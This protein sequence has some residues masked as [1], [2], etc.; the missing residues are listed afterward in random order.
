MSAARPTES[1]IEFIIILIILI[2][3]HHM[4]S[5]SQRLGYP[6]Y[7]SQFQAKMLGNSL[8][9][10]SRAVGVVSASSR[11]ATVSLTTL[12]Q[13]PKKIS[14]YRTLLQWTHCTCKISADLAHYL[15]L[16]RTRGLLT[17]LPRPE[18]QH[19][20][21]LRPLRIKLEASQSMPKHLRQKCR[22]PWSKGFGCTR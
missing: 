2:I 10:S 9:Q 5:P 11:A 1:L 18:K 6:F 8:T 17:S 21:V 19:P 20:H 13:N 22:R 3:I 16:T 12:E 14:L 4:C 15:H 7:F